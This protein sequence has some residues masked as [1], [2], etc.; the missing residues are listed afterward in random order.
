MEAILHAM[1]EGVKGCACWS[2]SGYYEEIH[3]KSKY[4]EY[5]YYLPI[6]YIA[7]IKINLLENFI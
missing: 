2:V 4:R 1:D 3:S 7:F 5:L 6:H